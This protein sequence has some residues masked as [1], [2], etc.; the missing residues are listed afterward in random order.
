MAFH[1]IA[2]IPGLSVLGARDRVWKTWLN[3]VATLGITTE[4]TSI[5][6]Y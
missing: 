4:F 1:F 5:E 3:T 6:Q 2:S